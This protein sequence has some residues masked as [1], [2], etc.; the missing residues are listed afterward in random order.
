MDSLDAIEDERST[1]LL[2]DDYNKY[3]SN[4]KFMFEMMPCMLNGLVIVPYFYESGPWWHR[5]CLRCS[6]FEPYGRHHTVKIDSGI[7]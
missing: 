1:C 6:I 7:K 5:S 2:I 3:F 4:T